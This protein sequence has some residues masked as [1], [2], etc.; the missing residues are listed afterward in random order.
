M[1]R[2]T[3]PLRTLVVFFLGIG[4]MYGLVAL[5]GSWTPALGLDLEGGTRIR[6]AATGEGVTTESL[7]E[8]RSIIDA[9][10]NGTGVADILPF[11]HVC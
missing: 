6:L 9:R 10:V 7:D 5:A 8:A 2:R 3:N 4:V 1:A 11:P